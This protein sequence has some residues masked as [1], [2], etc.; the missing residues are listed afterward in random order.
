MRKGPEGNTGR[1]KLFFLD[2]IPLGVFPCDA[3]ADDAVLHTTTK[4]ERKEGSKVKKERIKEEHTRASFL[5]EIH[6][7]PVFLLFSF[8]LIIIFSFFCAVYGP[9]PLECRFQLYS[10]LCVWIYVDFVLLFFHLN[11][12]APSDAFHVRR[13]RRPSSTRIYLHAHV[14]NMN[15]Y[16]GPYNYLVL[17]PSSDLKEKFFSV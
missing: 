15:N 4:K 5:D 17:F 16:L 12:F 8:T 2:G 13:R 6:F 14:L 7:L 9:A 1:L 3:D 11:C 10:L